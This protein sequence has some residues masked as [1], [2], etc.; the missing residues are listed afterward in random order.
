MHFIAWEAENNAP[1]LLSLSD[2]W[3]ALWAASD[4]SYKQ[5]GGC[6]GCPY[7]GYS[8]CLR[9]RAKSVWVCCDS[10]YCSCKRISI[11]LNCK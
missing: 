4:L 5:V 9:P 6:H 10:S 7:N 8:V 11:N 2:T 1:E 3:E